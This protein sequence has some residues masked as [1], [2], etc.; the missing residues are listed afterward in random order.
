MI[1]VIAKL[2]GVPVAG[3]LLVIAVDLADEAVDIDHQRQLT[4]SRAGLPRPRERHVEH[5]VELAD[6]PKRAR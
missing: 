3:A 6:M 4:R 5:V 1:G 2:A